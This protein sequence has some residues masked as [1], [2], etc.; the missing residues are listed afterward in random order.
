L[1]PIPTTWRAKVVDW[2][3]EEEVVDLEPD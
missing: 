1:I 2:E 3:E